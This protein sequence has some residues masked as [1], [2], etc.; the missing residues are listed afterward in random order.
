MTGTARNR[1]RAAL[2]TIFAAA[3]AMPLVAPAY[4]T[5]RP[6]IDAFIQNMA[7][8]HGFDSDYVAQVLSGAS[9]RQSI[10]D[11]MS[12]PAE[13]TLAWHK[14]RKIFITPERIEAGV[15][16]WTD[17]KDTLRNIAH[18]TG[19]A[20]EML[21]GIIG[22]ETYF[23][24]ITGRYPVVDALATLAFDYPPRSR[25]FS[26]EL[27]Q[28]FLLARDERFDLGDLKG[29]YAGAMGAPQFIPSSYRAYA[30][31]GDGDGVRDLFGNWEDVIASVANYFVEHRWQRGEEVA[32][33]A[34]LREDATAPTPTSGLKPDK[35]VQSLSEAG[36]V[37]ATDLAAAAPA[38]FMELEGSDGTELW[39]GFH[40]FYVITRYNRSVMYAL[41]AWQLGQ[42]IGAASPPLIDEKQAPDAPSAG[43]GD[44]E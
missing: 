18:S 40:N 25:F 27:E 14:Y 22:V 33:S 43:N 17:H 38:S 35:T 5:A 26:R 20:P 41:A 34:Y 29:S 37:F 9:S 30:V 2:T 32:Q 31:D 19:V 36:V 7:S 28:L 12:R 6:E 8:E 4:D 11:A 39:V 15:E 16:F 13:R 23:G 24:R 42:A 3:I 21:V 44:P 1:P 10:L